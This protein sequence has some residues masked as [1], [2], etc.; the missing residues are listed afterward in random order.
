MTIK[1]KVRFLPPAV[2]VCLP[3][4]F[5][6]AGP[7]IGAEI[8]ATIEHDAVLNSQ[9]GFRSAYVV[10]REYSRGVDLT[11]LIDDYRGD[12]QVQ[13]HGLSLTE[14]R[15]L[16]NKHGVG[17]SIAQIS[18]DTFRNFSGNEYKLIVLTKE[19]HFEPVLKGTPD[20]VLTVTG[21]GAV[22]RDKR[23]FWRRM[24][25]AVVMVRRDEARWRDL[26]GW[27]SICAGILSVAGASLLH[28]RKRAGT[29]QRF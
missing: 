28:W 3:W 19:H 29:K 17:T 12:L 15:Q 11:D 7:S 8:N 9:C 10:L 18:W 22:W 21:D 14:L 23:L 26:I 13:L 6:V 1:G 4:A 16:L 2:L 27:A 5:L 24:T 20:R 25:S